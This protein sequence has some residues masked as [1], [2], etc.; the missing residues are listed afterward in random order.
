M[1]Y[2]ILNYKQSVSFLTTIS[3]SVL[4]VFSAQITPAVLAFFSLVCSTSSLYRSVSS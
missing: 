4:A 3:I 2:L 1:Y